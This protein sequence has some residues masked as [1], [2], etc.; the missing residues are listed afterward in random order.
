LGQKGFVVVVVVVDVSL[1]MLN[2]NK[3]GNQSIQFLKRG[4]CLNYLVHLNTKQNKEDK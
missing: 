3:Y 2:K 4:L 1:E